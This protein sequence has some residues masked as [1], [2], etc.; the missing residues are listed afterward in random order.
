M[1][2][3]FIRDVIRIIFNVF[4]RA[5]MGSSGIFL[6]FF[7]WP[8]IET[9]LGPNEKHLCLGEKRFQRLLDWGQILLPYFIWSMQADFSA[10]ASIKN[11]AISICS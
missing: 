10:G 3:A 5:G 11:I 8:V 7:S 6:C 1:W 4:M 9:E 2:D